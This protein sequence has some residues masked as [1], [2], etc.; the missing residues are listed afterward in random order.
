M[1]YFSLSE[2]CLVSHPDA[3]FDHL[4]PTSDPRELFDA[5]QRF[6][7]ARSIGK[8][9]LPG[10][11]FAFADIRTIY[12]PKLLD[13][14]EDAVRQY[15]REANQ[16][17]D[18]FEVRIRKVFKRV[19]IEKIAERLLEGEPNEIRL[20][21]FR[22]F[23]AMGGTVYFGKEHCRACLERGDPEE[24]VR[25]CYES[26]HLH[27]TA[28]IEFRSGELARLLDKAA[29]DLKN[30]IELQLKDTN[31]D[32]KRERLLVRMAKLEWCTKDEISRDVRERLG[33]VAA[34]NI[35]SRLS[36]ESAVLEQFLVQGTSIEK[37][38]RQTQKRFLPF[39]NELR[40]RRQHHFTQLLTKKADD[41]VQQIERLSTLPE[42][43]EL[44]HEVAATFERNHVQIPNSI[45]LLGG[46]TKR[47][48][49]H[50]EKLQKEATDALVQARLRKAKQKKADLED[51]L[52]KKGLMAR[53]TMRSMT[54]S[55]EKAWKGYEQT[56]Q[57]AEAATDLSNRLDLTCKAWSLCRDCTEPQEQLDLR[58]GDIMILSN[59][60]ERKRHLDNAGKY[61]QSYGLEIPKALTEAQARLS[62]VASTIGTYGKNLSD[63]LDKN[64]LRQAEALREDL[65]QYLSDEGLDQPS[66]T[67]GL[68]RS[69][70]DRWDSYR[71]TLS[72]AGNAATISERFSSALKACDLCKDCDEAPD[73]MRNLAAR[74]GL[75]GADVMLE[76]GGKRVR[77]FRSNRLCI[78]R[79]RGDVSLS[80]QT[81]SS[82]P[83]KAVEIAYAGSSFYI[84]N[85]GGAETGPHLFVR[86]EEGRYEIAGISYA[87]AP[88]GQEYP[89]PPNAVFLLGY[90]CL[91][92]IQT[93]KQACVI[94]FATPTEPDRVPQLQQAMGS[95][96]RIELTDIWPDWQKDI[97]TTYILAPDVLDLSLLGVPGKILSEDDGFVITSDKVIEI[98]GRSLHQVAL[99]RGCCY[100]ITKKELII[101]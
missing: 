59:L 64:H 97:E 90:L 33:A 98:G 94:R 46:R 100:R 72:D 69:L 3:P 41:I 37:L 86:D 10:Y 77:W 71:K 5:F 25:I 88:H 24:A 36:E 12:G 47:I 56:L 87:L 53:E 61:I 51:Y 6:F 11:S 60:E 30:S 19:Q 82:K 31:D 76:I 21:T 91:L 57:T 40:Q 16:S 4:S 79:G 50:L 99:L 74:H 22:R 83:E 26:Y 52:I 63:C 1:I 80:L 38:I 58:I 34:A 27:K 17:K 20:K 44:F 85:K 23:I 70:K 7:E 32:V 66:N 39:T 29:F 2:D 13:G 54:A 62:K 75:R 18:K 73:I 92:E 15:D 28:W 49:S 78:Q 14:L 84:R 8:R 101:R 43:Q 9:V 68:L 42:R 45:K 96:A 55:I 93:N 67:S 35:E 65:R 81:V 48:S 95:T 89:L